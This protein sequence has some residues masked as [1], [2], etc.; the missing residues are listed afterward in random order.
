MTNLKDYNDIW[1]SSNVELFGTQ[2]S[3]E[4]AKPLPTFGVH[5][6]NIR[7]WRKHK[8]AISESATSCKK[9]TALNLIFSP[10][11]L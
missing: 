9:F 8:A 1:Q 6:S 11:E 5:E 3:R 4:T 2:R 10:L 7:L